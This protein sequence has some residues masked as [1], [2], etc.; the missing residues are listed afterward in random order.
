V[1][2]L[3]AKEA[4]NILG[5]PVLVEDTSYH[6]DALDGFP[7]ALVRWALDPNNKGSKEEVNNGCQRICNMVAFSKNRKTYAISTICYFDGKTSTVSEGRI[8]GTIPYSPRGKIGFGWD[9]I[10]IP[11]GFNQTFSEMGME[12]KNKISMRKI[13]LEELKRHLP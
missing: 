7:G 2:E 4:F 8:D 3:K 9:F 13:A 1:I 10:F 5:K 6:L 12:E 11:K